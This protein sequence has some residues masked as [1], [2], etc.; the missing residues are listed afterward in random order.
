MNDFISDMIHMTEG[1]KFIKYWWLWLIILIISIAIAILINKDK[2]KNKKAK[3]SVVS[4]KGPEIITFI[5]KNKST[6]K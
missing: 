3:K 4:E 6:R 2:D 5:N 1:E